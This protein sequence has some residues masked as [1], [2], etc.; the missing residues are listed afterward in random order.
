MHHFSSSIR[1]E[2]W[3]TLCNF[4]FANGSLKNVQLQKKIQ[5]RDF[6]NQNSNEHLSEP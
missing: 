4:D 5:G 6:S 2:K 3:C 1:T